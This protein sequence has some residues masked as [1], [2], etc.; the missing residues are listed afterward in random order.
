MA[1]TGSRRSKRRSPLRD[2]S[3]RIAALD[4]RRAALD[5]PHQALA[6]RAG[7]A[8]RTWNQMRRTGKAK[9]RHVEAVSMALRSIGKEL[10]GLDAQYGDGA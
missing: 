6:L 3:V 4:K 7:I 5:V 8:V 1:M 2:L 9:R 10:N